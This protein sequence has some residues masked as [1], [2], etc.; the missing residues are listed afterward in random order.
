MDGTDT[1]RF[2]GKDIP[3]SARIMAIVDVYDALRSKRLTR[4]AFPRKSAKIIEEGMGTHFDP[5]LVG[6]F[7]R[8][9]NEFRDLY[10]SITHS[11][12]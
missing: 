8:Y 3:L 10:D 7:L 4:K 1:Q 6:V 5:L 12:L 11:Y 9:Q 2:V